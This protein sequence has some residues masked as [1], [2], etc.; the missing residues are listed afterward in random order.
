VAFSPDGKQI[1]SA[2]SDKMLKVW[3]AATGRETRT[4][5][6]HTD[7]VCK[8]AFSP[9]GKRVVSG[10]YDKT[11]KVW[12]LATGQATRTLKGHGGYVT[13]AFSPDGKRIASGSDDTTVKVWD[14]DT[15]QETLTLKGHRWGVASLAF[16]PDGRRIVSGSFDSTLKV[17]DGRVLT[18]E[19][20]AEREALG[21]LRFWF[22]QRLPRA[23]V[24]EKIRRDETVTEE[25]RRRALTLAEEW[26]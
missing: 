1:V 21:L 9:D 4:L 5:K 15:G 23:D 6:G 18:P 7:L 11:L 8:V 25:V 24:L 22:A 12:D 13:V 16:S 2:S 26:R 10:S 14:A 20:R 19:L 3:D 17:W